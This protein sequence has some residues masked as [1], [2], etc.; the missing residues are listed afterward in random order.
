MPWQQGNQPLRVWPS[1]INALAVW[2]YRQS[3]R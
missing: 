3:S 1:V 2:Y